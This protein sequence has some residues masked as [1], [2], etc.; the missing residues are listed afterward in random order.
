MLR[1]NPEWTRLLDDYKA[2]HQDP[3]NQACHKVGIP[4]ILASLPIG[5][6][7]VGLP[8]AATLF[9][10]P[11][12]LFM[13]ALCVWQVQRLYWKEALINERVERTT[14]RT[15]GI[16]TIRTAVTMSTP[17]RAASGMPDT[18][19]A[20]SE[21]TASS[22][23]ECVIAASRVRPPERTLT[24]V[25]AIAPVAGMPPKSPEARDASP[26]PTSSR[27]GS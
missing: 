14:A 9:T 3:R 20:A 16:D 21:T 27:S 26:W 6:T 12:V 25:R 4:M 24:A 13:V 22:T 18:T 17:D 10:V 11:A 1:L 15:V 8:L 2:Q 7:V 19:V 5:A 23:S